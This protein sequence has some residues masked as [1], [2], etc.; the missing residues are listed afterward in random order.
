MVIS[1]LFTV[2]V[3]DNQ[4]RVPIQE[5][6]EQQLHDNELPIESNSH[7][8]GEGNENPIEDN[9]EKEKILSFEVEHEVNDD[10][11]PIAY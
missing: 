1:H 6:V 8:E 9:E 5:E 10:D 4:D 11:K 2:E 3:Q 7:E